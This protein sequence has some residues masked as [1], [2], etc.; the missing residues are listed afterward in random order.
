MEYDF[1]RYDDANGRLNVAAVGKLGPEGISHSFP[2]VPQRYFAGD[3][4]AVEESLDLRESGLFQP[5]TYVI[6]DNGQEY[7][8]WKLTVKGRAA[9]HNS[10]AA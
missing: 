1:D 4:F 6:E 5:T 9:V 3:G 7:R 2:A 8:I 10:Q